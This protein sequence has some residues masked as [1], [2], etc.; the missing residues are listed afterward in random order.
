M[1]EQVAEFL[2]RI[3]DAEERAFRPLDDAG[4]ADLPAAFAIE[5]RLVEDERT[6]LAGLQVR[7]LFAARDERRDD[8][9][10]GFGIVAEEL[11]W[12]R[13]CP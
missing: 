2:L 5:R 1:D 10:R 3:G 11:A 13:S 7:H 4:V 12:R 8:A 9:F 6:F